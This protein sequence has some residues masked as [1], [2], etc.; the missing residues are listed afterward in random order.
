MVGFKY[1]QRKIQPTS[2]R[3]C[4]GD[5]PHWEVFHIRKRSELHYRFSW[6]GESGSLG[7]VYVVVLNVIYSSTMANYQS[8]P[9][10]TL[11]SIQVSRE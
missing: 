4:G 6:L 1:F 2:S 3:L 10:S 5:P 7:I 8:Q 11:T 9:M